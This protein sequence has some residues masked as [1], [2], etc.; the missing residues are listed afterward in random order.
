VFVVKK[1]SFSVSVDTVGSTAIERCNSSFAHSAVNG[2][3][4]VVKILC[5][6]R[7]VTGRLCD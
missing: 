7:S 4:V 1:I 5:M 2:N 6:M 3:G